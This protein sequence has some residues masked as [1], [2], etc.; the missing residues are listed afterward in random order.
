MFTRRIDNLGRIVIPMDLRKRLNVKDGDKM[1][2]K[3]NGN[4][5]VINRHYDSQL[6]AVIANVDLLKDDELRNKLMNAIFTHKR[7]DTSD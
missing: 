3:L 7:S 5:I 4:T 2:I 6:D 1:D